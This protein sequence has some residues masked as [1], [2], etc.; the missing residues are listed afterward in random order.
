[1][2]TLTDLALRWWVW[3]RMEL[4]MK[5]NVCPGPA[6]RHVAQRG[7]FFRRNIPSRGLFSTRE[8]ACRIG[9]EVDPGFPWTER[10]RTCLEFDRSNVIWKFGGG[11]WWHFRAYIVG[12]RQFIGWR[13]SADLHLFAFPPPNL[14]GSA[15]FRTIFKQKLFSSRFTFKSMF[16]TDLHSKA[17]LVF[18]WLDL[19]R[20]HTVIISDVIYIG[21]HV[22]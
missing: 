14:Y 21:F 12:L 7:C 8:L 19:L 13:L 6:L 2:K 20:R 1:M 17:C 5:E 3:L 15:T 11:I 10:E 9:H 18:L 22:Y 16:F 4:K